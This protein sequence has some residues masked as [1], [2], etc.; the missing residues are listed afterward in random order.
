MGREETVL[1]STIAVD[2]VDKC[3][4]LRIVGWAPT[5]HK[6]FHYTIVNGSSKKIAHRYPTQQ[7]K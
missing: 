3:A 5:S 6:G 7:E 2:N 4:N 1:A